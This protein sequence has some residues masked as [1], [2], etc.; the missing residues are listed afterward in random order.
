MNSVRIP[1]LFK[2]LLG[3][4]GSFGSGIWRLYSN[5]QDNSLIE[6]T[7]SAR[8]EP[9]TLISKNCSSL[10]YLPDISQGVLD[11]FIGYYL[12]AVALLASIEDVR[13]VR[14]LDKLN[15]DRDLND[16]MLF[17]S[18]KN[19]FAMAEEC[20]KFKLPMAKMDKES[21]LFDAQ[22]QYAAERSVLDITVNT[23]EAFDTPEDL[24]LVGSYDPHK[25]TSA[26]LRETAD[27]SS[28]KLINVTIKMNENS[29]TVPVSFRLAST[30]TPFGIIKNIF[31]YHKDDN[32]FI[33]RFHA[34]RSGRISLIRDL[35]LCQDLIDE[36]KKTMMQDSNNIFSEI[37]KRVNNN[38]KYGLLSDNPSLAVSSNIFIIN[39]EE[40]ASVA[41]DLGGKFGSKIVMRKIFDN[42][43]AMIIV[44]IDREWEMVSFYSRGITAPTTISVKD[45]KKRAKKEN[46]TD[47][48]NI[49]KSYN[50]GSAPTF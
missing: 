26:T 15:P 39:E 11:L 31:T 49:L 47:I 29:V 6:A 19:K 7:R 17:E 30:L 35:I 43:Y 28:G 37:V 50:L 25:D 45:I 44:V 5:T 21:Q 14:F 46:G 48:L 16:V 1:D 4:L 9:L 41:A 36:S 23:P 24:S 2:S 32:T 40:A 3:T 12:Q 34:W 8:V 20:Y 38:K 27:L 13:V 22:L 33:E 42:S 10:E 18:Y